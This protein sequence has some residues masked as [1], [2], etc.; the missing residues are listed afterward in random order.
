MRI[1]FVRGLSEH[2]HGNATGIGLADFTTTR[3]VQN[4]NYKA[5]VINCLTAGYPEGANLPVHFDTD[6]E[7]IDAA[8]V[9]IGMREPHEA[10]ILHIRN[11]LHLETLADLGALPGSRR[12][13]NRIRDGRSALRMP[14]R[15]RGQSGAGASITGHASGNRHTPCF[16][17]YWSR[18]YRTRALAELAGPALKQGPQAALHSIPRGLQSMMITIED[19]EA[20]KLASDHYL[21][22]SLSPELRDAL[23]KQATGK[24]A[25]VQGYYSLEEA[26]KILG[27]TTEELTQ[28]AQKREVRAFAD[29]GTWRFRTQDVEELARR[30]G[31]GSSVEL[32]VPDL[33]SGAGKGDASVFNFQTSSESDRVEIGQEMLTETPGSAR[34]GG[35]SKPRTPTPRASSDSDVRLVAEG[36]AV[37]FKVTGDSD[38]KVSGQDDGPRSGPRKVSNKPSS[39]SDV[40]IVGDSSDEIPLGGKPAKSGTD[41]DVRLDLRVPKPSKGPDDTFLTEEVDLDAEM[42]KAVE[43]DSDPKHKVLPGATGPVDL[44]DADL[45]RVGAG[46][47]GQQRFRPRPRRA[48]GLVAA[49]TAHRNRAFGSVAEKSRGSSSGTEAQGRFRQRQR[50]QPGQ[51]GR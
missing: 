15:R 45:E 35:G 16:P 9:I 38:V 26:A 47:N 22:Q 7:V 40:K 25:M 8:L 1:I 12:T 23:P 44:S 20:R 10:R 5:T 48:R 27:M 13:A 33:G 21:S 31:L 4:M 11:T 30:R 39:D 19:L 6:R 3:L 24:Q 50:H 18:P 34:K 28:L 42:R 17:F 29:R 37:S 2:T 36:G 51:A 41:S 49:R 32:P 14:L 46:R 43:R